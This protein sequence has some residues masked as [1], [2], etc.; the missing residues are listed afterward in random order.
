MIESVSDA[1]ALLDRLGAPARLMTHLRLVGEAAEMLIQGYAK[2]GVSCDSDFVLLGTA[3]HDAGKILFPTEL[4]EPGALH[5]QAGETLL[6]SNGVQPR[7][8]KC[9]VTH[10]TWNDV[11]VSF[12]ERS[13]AL[14]DKLWK[15]KRVD[16]LELMVID[17]AAARAGVDRWSLFADLDSLFERIA[18]DGPSRLARSK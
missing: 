14:A 11:S 9:C 18:S 3:I 7:V 15:G 13:I 10:A 17:E 4:D 16:E 5:E 1:H 2:L 8:A 6:L 12:E